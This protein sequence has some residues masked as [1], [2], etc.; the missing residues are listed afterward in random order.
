MRLELAFLNRKTNNLSKDNFMM[1]LN[2]LNWGHPVRVQSRSSS[3][4]PSCVKSQMENEGLFLGWTVFIPH[5]PV[6]P[7]LET[8]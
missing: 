6:I 2:L 7:A 5:S 3:P 8:V 1:C 4:S